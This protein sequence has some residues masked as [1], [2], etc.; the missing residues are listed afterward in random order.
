MF[1]FLR[2]L[3]TAL[4]G[5]PWWCSSKELC[6]MQETRKTRARSLGWEHP[7]EE[8][9]ATH[10]SVLAGRI[11]W[12]EEPGGLQSM[13]SQ[14]V[15]HDWHDWACKHTVLHS[16]CINL[17]S[18]QQC[19]RIPFSPLIVCR[20]LFIIVILASVRWYLIAVLSM[21][22][23]SHLS[24]SSPLLK[25]LSI[26]YILYS[27]LWNGNLLSV[28]AWRIP[29][30][31]EPGGLLSM[32]SHRVR[33]DWGDLA[34]AAFIFRAQFFFFSQQ[35]KTIQLWIFNIQLRMLTVSTNRQSLL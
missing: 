18:H 23:C 1:S 24:L 31:G 10:S 19:R 30:A 2:N 5:L 34:A 35:L 29:G 22:V 3:H 7:L 20:F 27:F 32:G 21:Y 25:D 14:R 11:P 12:T 17:H 15:R 4:H 9:M 6:T 28:L 8:G 33:H 13:G 26:N 16:G